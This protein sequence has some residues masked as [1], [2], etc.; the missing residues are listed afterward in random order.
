MRLCQSLRSS[1]M[2]QETTPTLLFSCSRSYPESRCGNEC[3][4]RLALHAGLVEVSWRQPCLERCFSRGPFTIDDRE[5]CGVAGALAI[6]RVLPEQ[7]F[8]SEAK[9]RGRPARWL[10]QAVALPFVTAVAELVEG[11][12]QHEVHRLRC[13]GRTLKLWG[14]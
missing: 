5:P 4:Q 7:T 2:Q 10:V 3:G 1:E 8:V 13:G 12:A 14:K 6:D 9:T 11:A